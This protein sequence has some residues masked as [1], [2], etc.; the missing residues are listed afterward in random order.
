M[1][2]SSQL[3]PWPH[4]ERGRAGINRVPVGI[5]SQNTSA[6][7]RRTHWLHRL[8]CANPL[9]QQVG[10]CHNRLRLFGHIAIGFRFAKSLLQVPFA[11]R[12]P[13]VAKTVRLQ[14]PHNSSAKCNPHFTYAGRST[15]KRPRT[16][17]TVRLP[18][19]IF[20]LSRRAPQARESALRTRMWPLTLRPFAVNDAASIA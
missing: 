11:F 5:L 14:T 17:S 20:R 6:D 13:R 19:P 2:T 4:V 15:R 1:L 18:T 9:R 8:R 10:S 3:R 12:S 16:L 7:H